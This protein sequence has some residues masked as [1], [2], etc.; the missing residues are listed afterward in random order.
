MK[1][2]KRFGRRE[3]A[4]EQEEEK[5][6]VGMLYFCLNSRAA[7]S[8]TLDQL[9]RRQVRPTK[10]HNAEVQ[11]LLTLMGIPWIVVR[12]RTCLATFL[13]RPIVSVRGRSTMC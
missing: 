10:E 2:V 13:T 3:E 6:D 8:E 11:R 5:K 9:A 1:L 4:R 7:D 12:G